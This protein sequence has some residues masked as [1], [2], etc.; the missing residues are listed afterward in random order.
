[1]DL[2]E[3]KDEF[4]IDCQIRNLSKR[5]IETYARNIGIIFNMLNENGKNKLTDVSRVDIKKIIIALQEQELKSTYINILMKSVKVCLR[6]AEGEGYLIDNPMDKIKLLKD[7]KTLLKTFTDEEVLNMINF[8]EGQGFLKT[9]NKLILET[10]ADTGLRVSELR[11]LKNENIKDGYF[12][13]LG[14]GD[15]ERVVPL[16]PYLLNRIK[17]Y[18]RVKYEYFRNLRIS[19]EIEDYLFLTKSGKKMGTNLMIEKIVKDSAINV[20]VREEVQRKSCHSLR[21]YF[22]QK[23]LKT[24]TNIYTISRLLGHSSI[25]TTQ[26]YLNSL[27][28]DE[29][30]N[31]IGGKTPMMMLSKQ[32]FK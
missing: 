26:I 27:T 10:F 28:D 30:L 18:N 17:K 7:K 22:A 14:K 12:I 20:G 15:K 24:G 1:M 32:R 16:S 13:V 9:R 3:L 19:R 5:T 2:N 23:L 21:H 4:I 29:I 25:K 31:D 8:Y 11:N 6:Y